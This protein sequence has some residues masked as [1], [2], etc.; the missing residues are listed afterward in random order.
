[1]HMLL[2]YNNMNCNCFGANS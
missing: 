2:Y 1:M